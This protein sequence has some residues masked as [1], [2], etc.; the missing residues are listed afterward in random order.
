VQYVMLIEGSLNFLC[1]R[2]PTT[3]ELLRPYICFVVVQYQ[4]TS[5]HTYNRH[6]HRSGK[7]ASAAVGNRSRSFGCPSTTPSTSRSSGPHTFTP[8]PNSVQ[9]S[10]DFYG[11]IS[12]SIAKA[13]SL[14]EVMTYRGLRTWASSSLRLES[15]RLLC[16]H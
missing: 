16:K 8:S 4:L 2:P 15:A 10:E 11:L 14:E 1:R 3:H 7:V 9:Y 12:G 6:P 13:Y 5:Q